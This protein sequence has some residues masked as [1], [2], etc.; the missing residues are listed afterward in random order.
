MCDATDS[1]AVY[2]GAARDLPGLRVMASNVAM[3]MELVSEK[4][5]PVRFCSFR[6]NV[7]NPGEWPSHFPVE[8][9]LAQHVEFA[10]KAGQ[11]WRGS[12]TFRSPLHGH[13]PWLL[14]SVLGQCLRGAAIVYW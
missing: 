9:Q 2:T 11:T 10:H 12:E 14:L 8:A 1:E 3:L 7:W 5:A 6:A 13:L 4:A